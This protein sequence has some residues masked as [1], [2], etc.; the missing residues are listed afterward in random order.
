LQRDFE[1]IC[2]TKEADAKK[3]IDAKEREV[4]G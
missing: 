1:K 2:T 3:H 4:K